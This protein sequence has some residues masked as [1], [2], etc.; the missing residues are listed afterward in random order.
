MIECN[1]F[2]HLLDKLVWTINLELRLMYKKIKSFVAIFS[3]YFVKIKKE[4]TSSHFVLP[5]KDFA[6]NN[7]DI[8]ANMLVTTENFEYSLETWI[9][10]CTF[11]LFIYFLLGGVQ[12]QILSF[13]VK[14]FFT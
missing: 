1:F 14:H 9:T 10:R 2:V 4:K 11:S 12:L 8:V 6:Q 13:Y 5:L 7:T 3:C